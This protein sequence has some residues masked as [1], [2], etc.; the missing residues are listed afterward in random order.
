MSGLN[1]G[2][3]R[4]LS[5]DGKPGDNAELQISDRSLHSQVSVSEGV[6]PQAE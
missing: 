3:V 1:G 6:I 2:S 4:Y 5:P